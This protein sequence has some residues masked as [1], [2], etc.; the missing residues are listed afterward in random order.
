M[1]NSIK[2][3]RGPVFPVLTLFNN[4]GTIDEA[5]LIKYM[6]YLVDNGVRAVMCTVGTSRYDVMTTEEIVSVNSLVA[7][8]VKDIDESVLCIL[9][10]P[11]FG[12]TS[13]SIYFAD[14]AAEAGADA[15]LAFYP[16]RYYGD[17][18]IIDYFSDISASS[19]I[20]IMIHEM[21]M[22]AGRMAEAPNWQYSMTAID[23]ILKL[24]NVVGM[25][26]E[27]ADEGLIR[28]INSRY[29]QDYL[30]IG[31]RGGMGAHLNARQYGQCSYLTGIGNIN[32]TIELDFFNAI[33]N[34]NEQVA[35]EIINNIEKP[36]FD[37]AVRIGWHPALKA[38]MNIAGLCQSYERKPMPGISNKD[39]QELEAIMKT[40]GIIDR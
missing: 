1:V 10:T 29:A 3:Y 37:V 14:A 35:A 40:T 21:Q 17:A 9:T 39:Y 38:A 26:E 19:S 15:M 6:H 32:P 8:T 4:D 5:G 22:R 25:K 31:G 18:S 28:D 36:F 34:G 23:E 24:D 20:G 33:E 13:M 27:S 2:S 7:Q 12:P 30:I 11:G 16:D